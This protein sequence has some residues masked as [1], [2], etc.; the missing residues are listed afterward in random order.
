MGELQSS[1][2]AARGWA[3]RS[4]LVRFSY[5]FKALL[6]MSWKLDDEESVVVGRELDINAAGVGVRSFVRAHAERMMRVNVENTR[7]TRNHWVLGTLRP[8]PRDKRA[9]LAITNW[10]DN[11]ARAK[12]MGILTGWKHLRLGL[13]DQEAGFPI[14]RCREQ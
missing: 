12:T 8:D 9:K 3:S 13:I 7:C 1:S 14:S 4:L 10:S 6:R 2:S 5:A 11:E